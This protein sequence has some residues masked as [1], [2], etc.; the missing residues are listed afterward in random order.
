MALVDLLDQLA[1]LT[2]GA[3]WSIVIVAAGVTG[4]ATAAA[5]LL[6]SRFSRRSPNQRR[7]IIGLIKALRGRGR[8]E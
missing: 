1:T 8:R 5:A 3:A 7:D 4:V 6:E 2:P